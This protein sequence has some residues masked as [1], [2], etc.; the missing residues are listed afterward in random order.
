MYHNPLAT[1]HSID[2]N[3]VKSLF[4]FLVNQDKTLNTRKIAKWIIRQHTKTSY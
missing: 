2:N 1:K 4:V 3:W